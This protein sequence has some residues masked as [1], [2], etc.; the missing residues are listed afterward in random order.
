MRK[1]PLTKGQFALVDDDDYLYLMKYKWRAVRTPKSNTWY[2]VCSLYYRSFKFMTL[3]MHRIICGVKNTQEVDH[4]D[5]NGLNNQKDNLRPATRLQQ[6]RNTRK[7]SSSPFKGV[8]NDMGKWES[9]IT[10]NDNMMHLGSYDQPEDAAY[11]YNQAALKYHG[12]FACLND[13]PKG[14]VGKPKN[15]KN[16]S[17]CLCGECKRCKSRARTAKWNAE[18]RDLVNARRRTR[19]AEFKQGLGN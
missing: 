1:I 10:V 8:R 3:L 19:R 2:A 14:F 17:G 16:L 7:R 18:N 4:K 13:L 6:I 11:A 15:Q 5:R 9:C 12:E